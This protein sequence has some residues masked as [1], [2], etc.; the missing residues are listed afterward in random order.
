MRSEA[1]EATQGE[2]AAAAAQS[3]VAPGK[4]PAVPTGAPRNTRGP[5]PERL[6]QRQRTIGNRGV[7]RLLSRSPSQ[8]GQ[9]SQKVEEALINPSAEGESTFHWTANYDFEI[10]DDAIYGIVKLGMDVFPGVS[11]SEATT[12]RQD[13]R[14]EFQRLFNGKFDVVEDGL[15]GATRRLYLGMDWIL[16]PT[17]GTPHATV[18]LAPGP[19]S[20]SEQTSRSL[21]HVAEPATVHAHETA[22]LFGLLDEYVDLNVRDRSSTAKAGVREDHSIMGAYP[23]EGVTQAEMKDRHALRIAQMIYKAAGK[24]ATKLTV[25]R[26]K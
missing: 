15:L 8:A 20:T 11:S 22:H 10:S 2:A 18:A 3:S 14:K 12:A 21:W 1:P 5:S 25:K 6:L 4:A 23:V 24:G 9:V 19:P 13:A 26:A 17:D 7:A 16:S